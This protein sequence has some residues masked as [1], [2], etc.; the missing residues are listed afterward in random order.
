MD[1]RFGNRIF[2]VFGLLC[3]PSEAGKWSRNAAV[4][5]S[6]RASVT[7]AGH[8]KV[9]KGAKTSHLTVRTGGQAPTER[10][11]KLVIRNVATEMRVRGALPEP[12]EAREIRM[13]ILYNWP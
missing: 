5:S 13:E 2:L 6:E 11:R 10:M 4:H 7:R 1:D 8:G 9:N 12:F 3:L